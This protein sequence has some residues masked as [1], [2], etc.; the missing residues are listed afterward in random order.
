MLTANLV[1]SLT[2][3]HCRQKTVGTSRSLFAHYEIVIA[4]AFDIEGEILYML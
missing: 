4:S 3:A 1:L 2:V